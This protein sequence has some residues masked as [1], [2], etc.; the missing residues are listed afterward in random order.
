MTDS[1]IYVYMTHSF[2][3]IWLN[4]FCLHNSPIYTYTTPASTS[5]HDAAHLFMSIGMTD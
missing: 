2:M 3:S 1:P 5:K 4:C